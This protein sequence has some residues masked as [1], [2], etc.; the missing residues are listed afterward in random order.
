MA[1]GALSVKLLCEIAAERGLHVA[2]MTTQ[3]GTR[4][5]FDAVTSKAAKVMHLCR[6]MGWRWAAMQA[7]YCYRRGTLLKRSG[8]VRTG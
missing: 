3:K 6:A 2:Q 8:C 1:D 7:L 4:Q 5:C